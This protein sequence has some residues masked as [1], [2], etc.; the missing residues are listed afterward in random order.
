MRSAN[1]F[2]FHFTGRHGHGT[3]W[4]LQQRTGS[5]FR[6]HGKSFRFDANNT[7]ARLQSRSRSGS[8]QSGEGKFHLQDAADRQSVGGNDKCSGDTAVPRLASALMN[9]MI[10]S[11]PGETH[12]CRQ[13]ISVVLPLIHSFFSCCST[14]LSQGTVHACESQDSQSVV[15]KLAV[16]GFW[17]SFRCV[18]RRRL[19]NE[20]QEP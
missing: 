1:R 12:R 11:F 16:R 3:R 15:S 5:H 4:T 10:L 6:Q 8:L 7:T 19:Q 9:A 13:S 20:H 17:R 18:P 2:Y 14:V